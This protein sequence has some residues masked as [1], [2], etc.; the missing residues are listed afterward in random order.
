MTSLTSSFMHS[1][2]HCPSTTS[3]LQTTYICMN[4]HACT[5]THYQYACTHARNSLCTLQ[6]AVS[7]LWRSLGLSVSFAGRFRSRARSGI[8]QT[9]PHTGSKKTWSNRSRRRGFLAAISK[10]LTNSCAQHGPTSALLFVFG[11]IF[12]AFSCILCACSAGINDQ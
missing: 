11:I 2:P 1:S 4:T 8:S 7:C 6:S 12:E 10:S 3:M 9:P 5:Y